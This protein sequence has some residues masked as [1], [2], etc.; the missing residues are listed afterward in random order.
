MCTKYANMILNLDPH[1]SPCPDLPQ[2]NFNLFTFPGGESHIRIA[3]IEGSSKEITISHRITSF[4]KLGELLIA[5]DALK[6]MGITKINV[7]IPYFPAARQDRMMTA[8]EPL[9]VKIYTDI[10]NAQNYNRVIVFDPHSEVTPALLNNCEVIDNT[11][12]IKK[13][14]EELPK[15]LLLVSPDG[16]ALKKIYKL[17]S[18]LK[19]NKVVECSKSRNVNTG[20]VTNFQVYAHD[21]NNR[22]CLIVD[23]ICDGGGTFM[24]LAKAL[25][26]KNAGKLYLAVSHGIFSK[27]LEALS[28]VFDHIYTTDSFKTIHQ[29]KNFT[30]LK[31]NSDILKS[32]TLKN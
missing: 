19:E 29:A 20:E 25:K 8:G 31:L 9:T 14:M 13:A 12:F 23:D 1:F 28:T 4:N 17:A 7:V 3:P 15:E 5:T 11:D 2:I 16:G 24:G 6:R 32:E 21:L 30:Q 22:P 26:E 18:S 27:G 10:I